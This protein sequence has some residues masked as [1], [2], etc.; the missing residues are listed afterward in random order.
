[1]L[2]A[3]TIGRAS[4][5]GAVAG[6]AALILWPIYAAF[7]APLLPAFI[8]ALATAA[9]CGISVLWITVADLLFH[10]HRSERLIPL[11]VFDVAFA[12]LLAVPS[13]AALRALLA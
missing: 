10:R 8:A 11:R 7:Q 5:V 9:F 12:L 4:G 1:M 2:K 6:L 3:W 13:A